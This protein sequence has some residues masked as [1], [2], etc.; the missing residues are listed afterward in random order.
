MINDHDPAFGVN[1]DAAGV[2]QLL[3]VVGVAGE[4]E[5]TLPNHI[6]VG[7]QLVPAPLG[8]HCFPLELGDIPAV[9]SEYLHAVVH[10]VGNVD[11]AIC[12]HGQT[13]G[14]VQLTDAAA[15]GAD[16]GFPLAVSGELLDAVVA[17][18]CDV[19]VALTVQ[20]DAPRSVE[21]AVG[22]AQFAELADVLAV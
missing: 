11:V 17:P 7:G 12:V 16:G 10:P 1:L 20:R 4:S 18:V 14:T 2:G 19:D 9:G 3:L 5:R 8:K 22:A 6:R 21:L 13:V 15:R